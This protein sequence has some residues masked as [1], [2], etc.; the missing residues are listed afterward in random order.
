MRAYTGIDAQTPPFNPAAGM[1]R[2]QAPPAQKF[3]VPGAQNIYA[4]V[5]RADGQ[6][7]AM[8][9]SRATT[10][11]AGEYAGRAKGV[12]NQAALSGLQLLG[13]QQ[14]NAYQRQQAQQSIGS[15]LM[16]N[17]FGG[18]GLLGGLL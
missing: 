14:E 13:Q 8:D 4:D 2:L 16:K 17:M 9:L 10:Q 15:G 7:S 1:A 12:Q 5:S 18:G 11:Q 3:A 6:K